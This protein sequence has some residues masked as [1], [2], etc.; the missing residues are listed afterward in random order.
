MKMRSYLS[1]AALGLLYVAF[2]PHNIRCWT[3]WPTR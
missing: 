3:A 1:V 2:P